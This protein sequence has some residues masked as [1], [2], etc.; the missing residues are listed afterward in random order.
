MRK[1]RVKADE[2]KWRAC[3]EE[4]LDTKLTVHMTITRKPEKGIDSSK[5]QKW[6]AATR[7]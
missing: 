7:E 6:L 4:N 1:R 3:N 5:K 2:R